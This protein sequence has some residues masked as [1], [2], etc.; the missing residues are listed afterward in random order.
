[1][2]QIQDASKQLETHMENN[3]VLHNTI[4]VFFGALSVT[5]RM[6]F[7]TCNIM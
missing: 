1:M 2:K 3:T 5:G 7:I 6:Q 4:H